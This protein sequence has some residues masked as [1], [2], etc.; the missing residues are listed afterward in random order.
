MQTYIIYP[1][2]TLIVQWYA[3]TYWITTNSSLNSDLAEE[4]D[5]MLGTENACSFQTLAQYLSTASQHMLQGAS[6]REPSN[7]EG[8]DTIVNFVVF[9]E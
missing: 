3:H 8:G 2:L 6:C 5:Q 7:D 4:L 1:H 9:C